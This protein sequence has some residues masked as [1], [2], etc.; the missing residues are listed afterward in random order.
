M[1]E[2][3]IATR[4]LNGLQDSRNR[5]PGQGAPSAFRC[6]PDSFATIPVSEGW[7]PDFVLARLAI[8]LENGQADPGTGH[9]PT[10]GLVGILFSRSRFWTRFRLETQEWIFLQKASGP[11]GAEFQPERK[12][13]GNGGT[14][15]ICT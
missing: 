4:N 11:S 15:F 9:A 6:S 14:K 3:G 8:V 1:I 7:I 5:R 13:G 2:S 12:S 10:S